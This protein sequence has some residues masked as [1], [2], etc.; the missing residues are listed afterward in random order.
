MSSKFEHF[1]VLFGFLYFDFANLSQDLGPIVSYAEVVLGSN[2]LCWF[3]DLLGCNSCLAFTVL[4]VTCY[5]L[6][7]IE[8]KGMAKRSNVVK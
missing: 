4:V 7:K 6:I 2:S 3:K 5:S 8:K 1:E